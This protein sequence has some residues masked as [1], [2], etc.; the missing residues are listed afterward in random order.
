MPTKW[1]RVIGLAS[2]IM[3]AAIGCVLFYWKQDSAMGRMLAWKVSDSMVAEAPVWGMGAG[4][5]QAHY[6]TYQAEF[7]KANPDSRHTQVAGNVFHPFNE[8]LLLLIEFGLFGLLLSGLILF[9]VVKGMCISRFNP[10]LT[11][12]AAITLF[13]C[14]SYPMH[15]A[16]VC[17]VLAF[18]LGNL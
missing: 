13:S 11:C 1:R 15:Y 5:F 4:S 7:F 16:Y 9:S 18:C 14:F 10:F 8:F 17:I 3:V 2:I 6:M 12:I